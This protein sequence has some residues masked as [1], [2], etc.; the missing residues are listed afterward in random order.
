M[1]LAMLLACDVSVTPPA[2]MATI[3]V[4]PR[5]VLM[6]SFA[7]NPD[8]ISETVDVFNNSEFGSLHPGTNR[9]G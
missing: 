2:E 1:A 9:V 6:R 7:R 4:S 3:G 8:A 5:N